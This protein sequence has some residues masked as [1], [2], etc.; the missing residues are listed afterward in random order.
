[1]LSACLRKLDPLGYR[2]RIE[3][4]LALHLRGEVRRDGLE[5]VRW[6]NRLEVQWRARDIHPWDSDLPVDRRA[7][8]F[9]EQSME[10]TEAAIFRLFEA[11]PQVDVIDIRVLG[12]TA[13]SLM[14][15]GTV[16]RADLDI[17]H[18]MP[19]VRM[20]LRRLGVSYHFAE[21][22]LSPVDSHADRFS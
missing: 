21:S 18:S 3:R 5:L 4:A 6:C 14:I 22:L 20:R 10:D 9:V 16:C 7:N 11:F 2:R 15:A 8:L 12:P 1:M 19:S 17:S 13:E